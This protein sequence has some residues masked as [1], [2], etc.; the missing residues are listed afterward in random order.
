LEFCAEEGGLKSWEW[1]G[2]SGVDWRR[3]EVVLSS[4]REKRWGGLK[5]RRSGAE[6]LAGKAGK[7]ATVTPI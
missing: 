1:C 5:K 3:G 7:A 6:Q 4:W 2:G